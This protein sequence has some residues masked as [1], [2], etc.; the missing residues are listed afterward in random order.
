MTTKL[1][2]FSA[3]KSDAYQRSR[4]LVSKSVR[5]AVP[6][7]FTSENVT[8]IFPDAAER[9]TATRTASHDVYEDAYATP[10]YQ[11]LSYVLQLPG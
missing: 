8:I 10:T 6:Y 3:C 9:T 1:P 2:R 7:L 4:E 5:H 11:L